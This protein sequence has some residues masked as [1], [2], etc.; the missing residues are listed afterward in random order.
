[1]PCKQGIE[2]SN[3][4]VPLW[5]IAQLV[6]CTPDKREVSGSSPLKPIRAVKSKFEAHKHV[7]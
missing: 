2:S 1:M 6:E 7:P 4:S 5:A 3:S